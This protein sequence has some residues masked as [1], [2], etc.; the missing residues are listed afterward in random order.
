MR[1]MQILKV[2]ILSTPGV[3]GKSGSEIVESDIDGKE[4][5]N[6]QAEVYSDVSTPCFCIVPP[7]FQYRPMCFQAAKGSHKPSRWAELPQQQPKFISQVQVY[8]FKFSSEKL[9]QLCKPQ[10]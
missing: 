1:G 5:G 8:V 4:P 3:I 2:K 7:K 9:M 6:I 10:L